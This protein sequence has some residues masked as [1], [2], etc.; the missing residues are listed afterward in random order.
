MFDPS[1]KKKLR[2]FCQHVG[3][4]I[5]RYNMIDNGEK[6]LIG[7]SG[8]KDSLSLSVALKVRLD[9]IPIRYTLNEL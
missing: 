3:R 2:I 5:N 9:W 4:R 7:V 6:L 1:Q 8:G